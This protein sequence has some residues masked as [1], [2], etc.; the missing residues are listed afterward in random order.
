VDEGKSDRRP[1]TECV[2][3]QFQI[4]NCEDVCLLWS[5]LIHVLIEVAAANRFV[6]IYV[7]PSQKPRKRQ[8]CRR[9]LNGAS[10]KRAFCAPNQNATR[11]CLP[12]DISADMFV[13][14]GIRPSQ[15]DD[16]Q[17]QIQIQ[18]YVY[19]YRYYRWLQQS[20]F[21]AA[22]CMEHNLNIH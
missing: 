3:V 11:S 17:T 9:S 18:R 12:I 21:P 20:A 5:K 19:R 22:F 8:R 10:T 1:I 16:K 13:W 2:S 6:Q 4:I 14:V 15:S 7:Q